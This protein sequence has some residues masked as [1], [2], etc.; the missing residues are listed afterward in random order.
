MESTTDTATNESSVKLEN[1]ERSL[2]V[3]LSDKEKRELADRSAHLLGEIEQMTEEA[4]TAAKQGKAQIDERKTELRRVSTEYRDGQKFQKVKCVRKFIYRTGVVV[5]ERTDTGAVLDERP[6][7]EREKQKELP[8]L[9][10]KANGA[11]G[12]TR[13]AEEPK[14]K[15][16]GRKPKG[17]KAS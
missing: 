16:K 2:L 5:E 7:T 17:A 9:E 14:Q 13:A 10:A 6:M 11:E 3:P 8:G 4:K 12:E 1:F 15:G